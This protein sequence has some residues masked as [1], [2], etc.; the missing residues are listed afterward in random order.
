MRS[1]YHVWRRQLQRHRDFS[2]QVT[3]FAVVVGFRID[4]RLGLFEL[5]RGQHPVHAVEPVEPQLEL[6]QPVERRRGRVVQLVEPVDPVERSSEEE[7]V[8][9]WQQAR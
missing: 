9:R 4:V 3:V 8:T 7:L 2:V 6:V 1:R 5:G